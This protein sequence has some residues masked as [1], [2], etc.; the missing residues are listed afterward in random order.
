MANATEQYV[1][2]A[3]SRSKFDREIAE[4][5]SMEVEYCAR[6]WFL[7]RAHWPVAVVVLASNRTNPSA[8]VTAVQFDYTNY[9]AAPPSV[10]LVDP[11]SGRLLLNKEL[12]TRFLRAIPGQEVPMPVPGGPKMQVNMAQDLMQAYSPEDLPF[13]CVAGVKE[14]HDHPGHSGDP[15][16]IHRSA[17]EGRLVRLLGVISKYGLEPVNG[18]NVNLVPQVT[19]NVSEPPA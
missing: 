10:R 2:P 14:Y 8:I 9:D 11:F 13:L 12:P 5:R 7:V 6:G 16:E 3:V 15:W 18:F 17:G 19:F 4:F 1:D